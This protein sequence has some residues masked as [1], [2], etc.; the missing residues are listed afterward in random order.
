MSKVYK[1]KSGLYLNPSQPWPLTFINVGHFWLQ[2]N[3]YFHRRFQI[4]FR[5]CSLL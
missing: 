3:F 1:R 4:Y 2:A 5:R